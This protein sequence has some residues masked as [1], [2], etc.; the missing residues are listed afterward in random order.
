M[1]VKKKATRKSKATAKRQTKR[2]A[3]KKKN[4]K[5]VFQVRANINELVKEFGGGYCDRGD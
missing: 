4:G 2:R 1:S 3:S 5:D